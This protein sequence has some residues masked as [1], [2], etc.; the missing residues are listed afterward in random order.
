MSGANLI[1]G[2]ECREYDHKRQNYELGRK[3]SRSFLCYFEVFDGAF[4]LHVYAP[5]QFSSLRH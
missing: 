1:V 5:P 4:D 2:T 3:G